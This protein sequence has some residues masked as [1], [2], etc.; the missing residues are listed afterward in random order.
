MTSRTI[1]TVVLAVAALLS[2]AG[3]STSA[4]DWTYVA[5]SGDAVAPEAEA[6]VFAGDVHVHVA[7]HGWVL[8]QPRRDR[9]VLRLDDRAGAVGTMHVSVRQGR[10][11][12][13]LCVPASG[14]VTVRR[15]DP[16]RLVEVLIWDATNRHRCSG[17]ATVGTLTIRP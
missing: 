3:T 10:S 16:R 1:T 12:R 4:Y 7:P 2:V 14:N 5:R 9:F 11:Q 17:T 6:A 15:I 13:E 8:F